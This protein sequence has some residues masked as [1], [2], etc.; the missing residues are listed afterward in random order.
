MPLPHHLCTGRRIT[1]VQA[2][3]V[4][5]CGKMGTGAQ[6]SFQ[7]AHQGD[8]GAAA[9]PSSGGEHCKEAGLG[10][11]EGMMIISGFSTRRMDL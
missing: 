11:L 10:D 8:E 9:M 1:L 2:A 7:A 3:V 4:P 6:P 5:H